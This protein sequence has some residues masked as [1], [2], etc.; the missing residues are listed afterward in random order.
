V[1]YTDHKNLTCKN[2]NTERVMRW[3][4]LIEEFGPTLKYI[5]GPK[6]VVADALSRLDLMSPA[7]TNVDNDTQDSLQ[8]V[9]MA[10]SY[11]LDKDDLPSDAFPVTY[12]LIQHEQDKDETLLALAR[13]GA[14]HYTLKDFHGGG[15]TNR[16]LCY[17]DRIV[18]PK[19]LQNRVVHWYHYTLCHPG[20]NRT[21]ETISQHFYWKNM[22]DHITRDVSTCGVCQTQKKQRKRY[23][24]LPEKEA[25]FQPWERLCVDLIGPDKI[26]SKKRGR[27][28]PELKCITMIDPATGWFEIKQYDD[29]RSITVANIVEQEWLTRYP[30]PSLITLDRGSEF[31]GEDFREMCE[32]DYGIKRKVIATRNPQANA[33]VER[34]HQTL[35]NLIRSMELQ[36]SPYY[37]PDDPWGGI[38]AAASFAMR[39]TYHTT[40]QAT[41]GQLVFGRDMVLN[42][43]HL[44]DWTAIKA[45]KQE[46]IRKNNIIENSKRIPHQYRVGDKVMMESHRAN[47]YEQ[48]YQGPYIITKVHSNGT[49]RLK[50]GAVTD[51]VNIRRI[52][53]FRTTGVRNR[54]RAASQS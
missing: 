2:F 36:D 51:T 41:P 44:A 50:M 32:N 38:L 52:H 16:L 12:R 45:R 9:Q 49:V 54:R 43:Q 4:L 23:G 28:L 34:A 40:L 15:R 35:G 17:K 3:R 53:P 30:K 20:I 29:K 11:G 6:N 42:T 22:R 14:K 1:V 39:A 25:E 31:I 18:I 26:K 33:I 47:K 37:D 19:R 8:E 10:E 46:L 27:A 5:K 48:P 24:L 21:E 13:Q 7:P